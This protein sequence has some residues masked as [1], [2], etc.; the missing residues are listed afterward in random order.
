[1]VLG[2]KHSEDYK[3]Y[4]FTKKTYLYKE[5]LIAFKALENHVGLVHLTIKHIQFYYQKNIKHFQDWYNYI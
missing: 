3:S 5:I 4:F 1:M 2:V